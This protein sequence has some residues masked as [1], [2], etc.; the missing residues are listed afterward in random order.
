M[1]IILLILNESGGKKNRFNMPK[2]IFLK[3]IVIFQCEDFANPYKDYS[4]CLFPH[5]F[6]GK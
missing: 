6:P 5:L 2:I 1:H 3:Q 4:F